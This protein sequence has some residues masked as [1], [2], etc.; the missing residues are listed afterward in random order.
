MP[1][2]K[3]YTNKINK[4]LDVNKKGFIV[5]P[6]PY[7]AIIKNNFDARHTGRMDV[8]I[9]T[10]GGIETDPRSW[11][12]VRYISPYIGQTNK[13]LN[14]K[15]KESGVYSY[16]MWMTVPDPGTRVA[17]I[18]LEGRRNNGIILGCMVDGA[19]NHMIP[20]LASSKEWI[21]TDEVAELFPEYEPGEHYLPVL[22]FNPK[23]ENKSVKHPIK[24]ERPVNIELAKILKEQGLLGDLIRGQSFSSAQRD[25]N[26]TVYGISTP[27]RSENDPA[28]DEALRDK[29]KSGYATQEDLDVRKRMPGHSFTMDDGDIDGN[30]KLIRLRTSTGHQILMND[31]AGVIYVGTSSGNAWI[32]LNNAGDIDIYSKQT[33]NMHTENNFNIRA[34]GDINLDAGK[35]L[36]ILTGTESIKVQS[37]KNIE[38]SSKGN[39]ITSAGGNTD[40]SSSGHTYLVGSEIDL[41]PTTSVPSAAAPEKYDLKMHGNKLVLTSTNTRVP[42]REPW[43]HTPSTG[44]T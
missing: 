39:N 13:R 44:E 5:D 33:I 30:N 32:E 37:G 12:P 18:F 19:N 8:Y 27:G 43:N 29:L 21:K 34:G 36:N 22:E 31:D 14:D 35:G 24:I 11:I 6:G 3:Q 7:E 15:R 41:N 17:V 9:P 40:I 38:V 16:G 28:T 10:L 20:G 23:A 1:T 25:S 42:E 26:S 4:D 2:F